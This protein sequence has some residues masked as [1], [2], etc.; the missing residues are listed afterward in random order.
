MYGTLRPFTVAVAASAGMLVGSASGA[1]VPAVFLYAY[2]TTVGAKQSGGLEAARPKEVVWHR[3]GS[4][5]LPEKTGPLMEWS[6]TSSDDA[7]R[8]PTEATTRLRPIA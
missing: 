4:C 5:C 8:L 2:E 6:M 3:N 7:N 1:N